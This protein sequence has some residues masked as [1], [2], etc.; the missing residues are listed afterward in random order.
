MSY[1]TRLIKAFRALAL[2]SRKAPIEDRIMATG[3][4]STL[5]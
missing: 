2:P 1:A 5:R 3:K 4:R